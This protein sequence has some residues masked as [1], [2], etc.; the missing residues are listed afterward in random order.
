MLTLLRFMLVSYQYKLTI[1]GMYFAQF[2][3]FCRKRKGLLSKTVENTFASLSEIV[4]TIHSHFLIVVASAEARTCKHIA[5][6]KYGKSCG[7]C[8]QAFAESMK[9]LICQASICKC[10]AVKPAVNAYT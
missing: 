3:L 6:C 4:R 2:F 8:V 10:G 1:V 7:Y 5:L 9:Y